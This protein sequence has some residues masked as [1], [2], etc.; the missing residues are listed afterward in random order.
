MRPNNFLLT[1]LPPVLDGLGSTEPVELEE[2]CRDYLVALRW[3]EGVACP[4]CDESRRLLWLESRSK[5][6]CYTC[7]YQFSVTAQTLFHNSHLPLSKW[8]LGVHLFLEAP[9]GVPANQLKQALDCSYKTAW[10]AGHRIRLAMRRREP[11]AV[12][13][14]N[15]G[16]RPAARRRFPGPYQHLSVKYLSAYLDERNWRSENRGNAHVF[17]DTIL[18][19]L[20]GEGVSYEQLV[21]AH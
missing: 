18:A 3:P 20:R 14:L 9:D 12:A 4:R 17:R 15:P 11:V 7:R 8:F 16:L 21:A 2:R 10:F 1:N 5:W 6:H 13:P 19:L